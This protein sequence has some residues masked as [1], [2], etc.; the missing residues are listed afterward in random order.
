MREILE[1][2]IR[3]PKTSARDLASL[4]GALG[5]LETLSTSARSSRPT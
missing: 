4:V 5:R 3:D 1:A 2:R